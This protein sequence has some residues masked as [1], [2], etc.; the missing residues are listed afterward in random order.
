VT[1]RRNAIGGMVEEESNVE[2]ARSGSRGTA[3]PNAVD[4]R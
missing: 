2:W 4:I 1:A 3:A